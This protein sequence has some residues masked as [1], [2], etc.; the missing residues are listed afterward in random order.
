MSNPYAPSKHPVRAEDRDPAAAAARA[1]QPPT[2]VRWLV[3]GLCIAM[4]LLLYLDR[5]AITPATDTMLTELKLTKGEM[6]DAVGA[7]FLSL[8]YSAML[9]TLMALAVGMRKLTVRHSA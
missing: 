8:T 6:G 4:S 7:F 5:F 3:V 2:Q 9:F 1:A